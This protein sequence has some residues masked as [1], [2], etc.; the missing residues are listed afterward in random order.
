MFWALWAKVKAIL[1]IL[2]LK[3]DLVN[4]KVPLSQLPD[5][6]VAQVITVQ[7]YADLPATGDSGYVYNV[8]NDSDTSK[9]GAYKWIGTGYFKYTNEQNYY[10]VSIIGEGYTMGQLETAVNNI[11][12]AGQHVFFDLHNFATDAYVC[13]VHFTTGSHCVINDLINEK[14]Y[15]IGAT[16][17]SEQTVAN[18]VSGSV[19]DLKT[20]LDA[21]AVSHETWTLTASDGTTTTKEV[22]LWQS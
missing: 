5:F 7:T 15:G 12:L 3:A 21:S 4:N 18:Y 13:L 17:T 22:V 19:K 2:P 1:G 11:N 20:T 10:S 8:V 16:Y 9:N 6:V 14:V